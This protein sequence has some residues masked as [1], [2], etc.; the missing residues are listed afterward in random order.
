MPSLIANRGVEPIR[1]RLYLPAYRVSE[2]ARYAGTTVQSVTYWHYGGGQLGPALPGSERRRPLSYMELIEVAFVAFF[3]NLGV[4]L[5][6]IRRA[7]DYIAQNFNAE[8]PFVEYRFKSEGAHLLMDFEEAESIDDFH[9][10]IVAD[11]GGQL[12]WE[13]MMADKFA[14][15]DYELLGADMLA[16]IWHV[17]GRNSKVVIDPRVA[18]G[19]P[20][21]SGVPT[22]A[23]KGRFKAGE[24]LDDIVEDFAISEGDA[25]DALNFEGIKFAA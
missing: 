11:A 15:F 23:L 8:F 6:R 4:P 13:S 21:V 3:R 12:A 10:V 25:L 9:Q 1:R 7:R 24:S 17:A 2:A 16:L 14:E 18:F 19:A 22:W 5:Q 20:N